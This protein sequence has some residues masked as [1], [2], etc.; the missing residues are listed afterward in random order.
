M[1]K[2]EISQMENLQARGVGKECALAG[3]LMTASA[4]AGAALLNPW[5]VV[6][7]FSGGGYFFIKNCMDK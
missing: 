1:K 3:A 4:L 5:A 6:T 7:S 2:L